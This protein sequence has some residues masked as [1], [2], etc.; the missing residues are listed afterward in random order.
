MPFPGGT[1][2]E[3]LVRQTHEEPTAI[4][5]LRPDVP[6]EVADILRCLMA[7]E[8]AHRY[9]SPAELV[10]DLM[11]LAQPVPSA[12]ATVNNAPALGAD[13][14]ELTANIGM[15]PAVEDKKK[16]GAAAPASDTDDLSDL[17]TTR[18]RKRR[19][20]TVHWLA[21]TAAIL[22]GCALGGALTAG[23]LWLLQ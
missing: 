10:L 21:I 11:P 13:T 20:G 2:I 16:S 18:V 3:K 4:E 15:V 17:K 6:Q 12:W 7:K 9:Q 19:H 5:Q 1:S 8:P 23:L 14:V 22:T